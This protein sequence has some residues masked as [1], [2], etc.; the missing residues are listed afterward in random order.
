[1]TTITTA[2]LAL[3]LMFSGQTSSSADL[4]DAESR[5]LRALVSADYAA[6]D[7]LLGDDLT[8]THSTAKVDTKASYLEPLLSGRTR[9]TSLDPEDVQVRVYGTTGV[10]I[11]ALRS[12]ALVAGKE[13]R[14]HMRFTSTWVRRDDRWQM[15]AWQSTRLP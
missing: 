12:V 7:R 4:E 9:Y 6:L 8:Y 11:G 5:R 13:S 2:L 1:M 14:T 15:V 10:I 3:V